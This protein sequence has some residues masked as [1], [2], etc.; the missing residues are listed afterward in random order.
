MNGRKRVQRENFSIFHFHFPRKWEKKI[1]SF[2]IIANHYATIRT[3][4]AL[5]PLLQTT[6]L[7]HPLLYYEQ[8]GNHR[9]VPIIHYRLLTDFRFQKKSNALNGFVLSLTFQKYLTCTAKSPPN[10]YKLLQVMDIK[11]LSVSGGSFHIGVY[12][13][14]YANNLVLFPLED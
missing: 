3:K 1:V 4:P 7:Y 14:C 11:G 2:R 12:F 6:L 9:A 10:N 8:E 13:D 5:G